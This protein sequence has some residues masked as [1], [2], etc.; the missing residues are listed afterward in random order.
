[1]SRISEFGDQILIAQAALGMDNATHYN[2][3][4]SVVER[5]KYPSLANVFKGTELADLFSWRNGI[6][7]GAN[8]PMARLR[9]Y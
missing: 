2:P 3:G 7:S 8:I 9:Y 1:M 5:A 6:V 4:L